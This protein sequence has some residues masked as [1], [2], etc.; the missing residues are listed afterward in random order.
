MRNMVNKGFAMLRKH[1]IG[2]SYMYPESKKFISTNRGHSIRPL[3]YDYG[4][5]NNGGEYNIWVEAE[6]SI[7][8]NFIVFTCQFIR[9]RFISIR[10]T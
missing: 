9:T 1:K 7:F 3:I 5:A 6:A 2:A 10:R 4:S 8:Y